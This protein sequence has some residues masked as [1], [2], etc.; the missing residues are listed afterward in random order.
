MQA[1]EEYIY[2]ELDKIELDT[3]NKLAYVGEQCLTEARLGGNYIDRSGNL[4]SSTG[5][6][7]VNNGEIVTQVIHE[8]DKGTDKGT[9]AAEG[10]KFILELA[11]RYSV[12]IVLIIVAGMNYA[13]YVSA[14]GYNVLDSA[15]SLAERLVPQIMRELGFIQR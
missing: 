5:Y 1:V 9:G 4:R 11:Q 6:V 2:G 8:A 13:R 14:K 10:R 3:I 7:I 15:E 12:G